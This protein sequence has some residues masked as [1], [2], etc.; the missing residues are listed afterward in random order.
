MSATIVRIVR[1]DQPYRTEVVAGRH[2]LIADEP[3]SLGGADAGPAPYDLVLAGLGTCTAVTLR[4][5]TDRQGWPLVC[6]EVF[7]HLVHDDEGLRIERTLAIEGLD[8][9]QRERMLDI[10]Q[11]TPV[12]LTLKGGIAID[13]MLA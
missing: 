4:M 1:D 12:T 13:T 6:V 2:V 7:L 8:A 10:A 5:Y 3:A 9:A 11:R